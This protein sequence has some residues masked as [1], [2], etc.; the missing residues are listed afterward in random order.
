MSIYDSFFLK[1]EHIHPSPENDEIYGAVDTIA[2]EFIDFANDIARNGIREP[3]VLSADCYILS[4]HRRFAA[5]KLVGLQEVPV[6]WITSISR[7]EYTSTDWKRQLISYNQQRVKSAAV[8][9]KEAALQVDPDIAYQQHCS[10]RDQQHSKEL[11]TLKVRTKKRR[12]KISKGKMEMLQAAVRVIE[13]LKEYWPL[14]L[15]QV[16]YQLLNDPP[17]MNTTSRK[18][19]S[20]YEN[21]RNCYSNLSKV[22]TQARVEGLVSWE[23]NE[24]QTRPVNNLRFQVDAAQFFSDEFHNFLRGYH[25]D[26]L[27]SQLDHVELI[28][29]KLTAQ[30]IIL[31]IAK[32][33][34]VPMTVGRGYCSL[35]PRK[36]MVERFRK[37]GKRK[38]ILLVASDF[39]PDGDEIAES[40]VRSIRDDF[41]VSDVT[42]SKI[43]LRADQA[44]EWQLPA[45]MEAKMSSSRFKQFVEDHNSTQVFEL[46][47]VSPSVMQAAVEEGIRAAIDIEA[48]EREVQAERADAVRL[49]AMKSAAV[50]FFQNAD[51]SALE[52]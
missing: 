28:V 13:S 52:A 38:L 6:R 8:R 3:I 48:F 45:N 27:Q 24:D 39:D 40:F 30:N 7:S 9:L 18:E 21:T 33:Y 42:G 44:K 36:E 11:T 37:S 19:K 16:H 26:L 5:A 49:A 47:A 51:L 12:S 35:G 46:E 2:N 25:R 20:R 1:T 23:W 15:R 22:L 32:K 41:G 43:L 14:S 10:D 17:I 34:C 50:P 29:E 31:P 4:G